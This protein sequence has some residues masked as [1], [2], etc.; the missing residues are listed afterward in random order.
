MAEKRLLSICIITKNDEKYISDCLENIKEI[1]DEVIIADIGS[2]D[3][4]VEKAERAGAVVYKVDWNYDFG[5][6]KNFCM[7]KANGKWILFIQANE[8]IS[9]LHLKQLRKLLDNPNAEGYL[10]YIDYN[11]KQYGI[12][13]PVQ[14][15]RLLR[16]RKEYRYTFKSFEKISDNILSNIEDANIQ[17]AF[18]DAEMS[19]DFTY[20]IMLLNEEIQSYPNDCYLQYMY[21]IMLLNKGEFEQSIFHLQ[22]AYENSSSE[23]LYS[24]HLYKCLSWSFLYLQRYS[25]AMVIL[26]E[27]IENFSFYTDFLV[28]RGEIYR[29]MKKYGEAIKDL[30]ACLSIRERPHF[31]VPG[32]EIDVSFVYET[33]G[34]I[35]EETFNFKQAV[36]QYLQAYKLADTNYH[37]LYKISEL[38]KIAN[39]PEVTENL[40]NNSVD[41][42][43]ENQLEEADENYYIELAKPWA[44]QN[45][46]Q[47]IVKIYN[48]I[49]DNEKKED[50]KQKIIGYLLYFNHLDSADNFISLEETQVSEDIECVLWSKHLTKNLNEFVKKMKESPK[51][52]STSTISVLKT[53]CKADE[54]LLRFYK[55]LN[56]ADD[57][58]MGL[59]CAEVHSRI[60]DYYEKKN[61]KNMALL[62]Y[63]R[64]WSLQYDPQNEYAL[65]KALDVLEIDSE[66]FHGI[67]NNTILMQNDVSFKHKGDFKNYILG[68]NAF[69]KHQFKQALSFF[70]KIKIKESCSLLIQAYIACCVW[71]DD[72]EAEIISGE[73]EITNEFIMMFSHICKD[74][75]LRRLKEAASR[76]PYSG[77]LKL[78]AERLCK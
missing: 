23:Y 45:D 22:K 10:L 64:S 70:A 52:D 76:Y 20:R 78:E 74:D 57:D 72:K 59:T 16:N 75:I 44:K 49:S 53:P 9:E 18:R 62:A 11:A 8:M 12:F 5:E 41:L 56:I 60:G 28:L 69:K 55:N 17:I 35:Y 15:L 2:Q 68:I 71:F 26:N 37:C 14:S 31:L 33:L 63:L 1:S 54:S 7:D 29:Q 46:F 30:E 27:G 58:I 19:W 61:K 21:G 65:K 36:E 47:S 6:I 3:R 50:F 40:L 39:M 38:S 42:E 34:E 24:P 25:E 32:P 66:R 13:S 67:L 4:T 51:Y 73:Y 48:R 43:K 77:L